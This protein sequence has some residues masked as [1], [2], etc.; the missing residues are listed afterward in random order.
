LTVRRI[1]GGRRALSDAICNIKRFGTL[2]VAMGSIALATAGAAYATDIGGHE[3]PVGASPLRA[4]IVPSYQACTSANSTHH[5]PLSGASC[6]PPVPGSTGT[7]AVSMGPSALAFERLIVLTS[8]TCAPF[9]STKCYPDITMRVN[10]TDI[11]NG[12]T[13]TGSDY[14]PT[15]AAA[16]DL[17]AV[18]TLPGGS[19]GD[20]LRITD[21]NNQ[22]LPDPA[23]NKAAT[24]VPLAF[25]LPMDCANTVDPVLGSTCNVQTTANTLVPGAIVAN[26]RADIELGQIQVLD[27]GTDGSAGNADD[28][29]FAVQGIFVP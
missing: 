7:N 20:A 6:N 9:D 25:P 17:T 29:V 28:R 12:T 16:Q 4:S 18:Y 14:D 10:A 11:H 24:V 23:F 15:G 3:H 1:G 22:V 13:G 21:A 8:G 2:L 5:G 19:T 27:K 26:K